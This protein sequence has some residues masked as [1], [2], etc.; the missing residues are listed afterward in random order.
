MEVKWNF[1]MSAEGGDALNIFPSVSFFFL[2]LWCGLMIST[3]NGL[4]NQSRKQ[5]CVWM[6]P[7]MLNSPCVKCF[8][9]RLSS[10]SSWRLARK[11]FLPGF[12]QEKPL[13]TDENLSS[14]QCGADQ[15]IAQLRT[16]LF[17]SFSFTCVFAVLRPFFFCFSRI[18]RRFF[19]E[20]RMLEGGE[21]NSV[22]G[23]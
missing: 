3:Q 20:W 10:V 6:S 18:R 11:E 2:S 17:L 19:C 1:E 5:D 23:R 12:W 16:C 21:K 9:G 8:F 13:E 4:I 14:F 15:K 22:V 7:K